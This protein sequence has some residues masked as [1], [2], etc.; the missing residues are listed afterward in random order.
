MI[1]KG[2]TMV[3]LR[4]LGDFLGAKVDYEP[5]EQKITF[6]LFG[7]VIELIIGRK[8]AKVNGE[9]VQLSVPPTIISGRTLVPL[10]FV[11]ENLGAKVDYEAK[12]RTIT[13]SY[14]DPE[15]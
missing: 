14:P 12:S 8:T 2:S 15:K 4:S 11:S 10:R 3:P 5:K 6:T 13:I 9:P 1:L 7:K